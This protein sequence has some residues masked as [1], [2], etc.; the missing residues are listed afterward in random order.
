M[1]ENQ[2][3]ASL[4]EK[5]KVLN[6][7]TWEGKAGREKIEQWLNNFG[8]Q[9]Q[10]HALFLLSRFMYFGSIQMRNLLKSLYRDLY[11]YKEFER[12]RRV[13]N[14]T[15]DIKFIHD[16]FKLIERKTRFL[17][18]GNPSESG[19]HLLYYFRQENK[20]SKKL[21]INTHE[22]I[23]RSGK[24][25]SLRIPGVSHYVF[26]DDFCGSGK[27]ATDYSTSVIKEL[28]ELNP[29]IETSYF[30]LF[31][32]Q[33]GKKNV[34]DNTLFD[35]VESV[36]ELDNSFKCFED[37]SRIFKNKANLIDQSKA[38][39]I[40]F[41]YGKILMESICCMEGAL[42][43]K[44]C[45]KRNAHGFSNGQLI[46]GFHHNTPDNCLPIFWY[47]EDEIGWTPIF[48]RYNKKY[49]F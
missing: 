25:R 49:G 7:T 40:S 23:S 5:I 21:F 46:I 44:A 22:I 42:D 37:D 38:K 26:I 36:F 9:E 2:L 27:Q 18:I 15:R 35:N 6:E 12:I 31:G 39:N 30:M 17:G 32:T 19:P 20:I 16:Q 8:S 13:N 28:K 34:E 33:S 14:H 11:K 24:N 10:T 43:I 41:K 47:D 48:K 1:N 3:K 4:L 45:A 29:N